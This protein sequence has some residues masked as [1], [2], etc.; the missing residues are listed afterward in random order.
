MIKKT[1]EK[2]K[3]E[4]IYGLHPLIE[5]LKAKRRKV[6]SI[7]T[8]KP[9]PKGWKDIEALWPKYPLPIQY[10]TRDILTRMAGTTDHQGVVSWVHEFPIRKK[11]FEPKKHPMLIMLDG[12][13]DPRNIGAILRSAYCTGVDGVIVTEKN[14]AP[15]NATV[16]KSSAGLAEYLDIYIAASAE[17]AAQDLKKAGYSLY[18]A[19]FA[20][21]NAIKCAYTMP[22]CLVVGGEGFGIS[23]QVYKYGTEITLPQKTS[24]ISYNVSVAAGLLLF[25]VATQFKRI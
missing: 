17:S 18:L 24:D 12:L 1:N 2:V 21:E 23:K 3:G 6:I 20:G 19:S 5:V 14:S 13:Q 25:I 15:F 22:L 7:Y 4:L 16:F 9:T 8:T 10:V 11:F